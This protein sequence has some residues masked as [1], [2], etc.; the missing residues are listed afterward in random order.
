MYKRIITNSIL[1]AMEDTPAVF[2]QGARQAGK[3]TLARD[4]ARS[5]LGAQFLTLDD[6]S[7][8]AAARSDPQGFLAGQKG[9]VVLDEVQ[10]VP[11]LALALKAAIDRDRTPGRYLLTGSARLLTLPALSEALV[12]RMEVLTLW[13][14]SQQELEG[15]DRNWIDGL[16]EDADHNHPAPMCDLTEI[17][18][19]LTAGG[20]PE[21]V[22]R[23]RPDR[24]ARWY[25]SYVTTLLQREVRDLS[26][27]E[28]LAAF[29]RLL[30]LA[31]ARTAQLTNMSDLSRA[32]GLPTSTLRRYMALLEGVFLVHYLPAWSTN[33]TKRVTRSP[34]L[35]L[36]DSGLAAHLVGLE[37]KGTPGRGLNLGGL[38]ETFAVNEVIRQ[39][40]VSSTRPSAFHFRT[41]TGIEVDLL[42]EDRRGRLVGIEIKAA[43]SVGARDLRGLRYLER[44]H[45]ET[46]VQGVVLYGGEE[47]VP[48]SDRIVAV[49]IGALW[50][51]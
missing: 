3:T 37:M 21:A 31:A 45:P 34:K 35:H 24:R 32:A 26:R 38:L 30:A 25:E 36:T 43:G 8:L 44:E 15:T 20:F 19:R 6:A 29:P 48:F 16:F 4:L 2:L 18:H 51:P 41:H 50:N 42:L 46:F 9:P 17:R 11:D 5:E 7:V 27:V 12:G 14:L 39:R 33:R 40:D 1:E 10:R 22:A 13:P 49:P 23:S 28:D 47:V